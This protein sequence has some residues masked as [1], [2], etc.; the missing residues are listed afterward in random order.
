MLARDVHYDRRANCSHIDD[1][2]DL[3]N[4]DAAGGES[5]QRLVSG[6]AGEFVRSCSCRKRLH[7]CWIEGKFGSECSEPACEQAGESAAALQ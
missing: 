6:G 5:V 2:S 1:V 3:G 4:T 7:K